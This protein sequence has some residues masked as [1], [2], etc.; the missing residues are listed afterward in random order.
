MLSAENVVGRLPL[1]QLPLDPPAVSKAHALVRWN[2]TCWELRD[3]GSRNGTYLGQQRLATGVTMSVVL[4]ADI[5]FGDAGE[6]WRLVDDGAPTPAA[7]PTDGGP[8]SLMISGTIA[9]PSAEQPLATVCADGDGWELEL[10][11]VRRPLAPGEHFTVAGREWRFDCPSGAA[12]THPAGGT[13]TRIGDLVLVFAVSRNE[14]QVALK[15]RGPRV[16]RDLG[17]RGAFYLSLVLCEHRLRERA[18]GVGEPGWLPVD[19]LLRMVPDYTSPSH[20]NVEICRLRQVLHEVGVED[21]WRIVE[22]RRGQLRF[23]T[24]RAEVLREVAT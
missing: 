21:A 16:E 22:R 4:G 8:V 1:C 19:D 11:D 3:L 13:W 24:D 23:G 10:D 2:G 15:L 18:R 9:V 17:T 12:P 7:V 5:V 14:E 6:T 20:V